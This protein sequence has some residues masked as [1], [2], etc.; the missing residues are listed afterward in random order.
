MRSGFEQKLL[1]A[2]TVQGT[3]ASQC[4]R[5]Y[6]LTQKRERHS[7]S[8][9]SAAASPSELIAPFCAFAH[10]RKP[11]TSTMTP[12]TAAFTF[13]VPVTPSVRP[14]IGARTAPA[15]G[16]QFH[17]RRS[18]RATIAPLRVSAQH[19]GN[20]EDLPVERIPMSLPELPQH[21]SRPGVYGIYNSQ[22]S[23]QYVA[24]VAN[25]RDAIANHVLFVGDADRCYAV[26]MLTVDDL[27]QKEALG[28][29]AEQWVI[30][31]SQ[32]GP[33]IPPGNSDAAPEWRMERKPEDI[34]FS[35]NAQL[36]MVAG[37]IEDII[38]DNDVVL[39][40]KGTRRMPRCGFSAAVVAMLQSM[41]D[42]FVCVDCLNEERNMGLRGAIKE[43]SKWPTIPQLYVR[44]EFV[45][46]HDIVQDMMGSGELQSMLEMV[47]AER[48]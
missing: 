7:K 22:N 45:G 38:R 13:S 16:I 6:K 8:T 1:S 44:G 23:L 31:H 43:Y 40:M 47:A 19:F 9:A 2:F 27:Q 26:R 14:T 12:E 20:V 42:E 25:V 4:D 33:G 32:H 48:P 17:A 24:A 29:L 10:A 28:D 37:E 41:T 36:E 11:A 30:T 18:R 5:I 46:G 35:D 21:W 39:F 3:S 34:Y 15:R